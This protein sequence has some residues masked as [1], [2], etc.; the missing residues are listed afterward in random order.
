MELQTPNRMAVNHKKVI[1]RVDFNV[2]LEEYRGKWLVKD[3]RR[4]RDT[5]RTISYLLDHR[6]KVILISHLGRPNGKVIEKYSLEPIAEH[7]RHKFHWPVKFLPATVGEKVEEAIGSLE[8]GQCLLLENLRF[9]NEEKDNDVK[10]AQTLASYADVYINEAFSASHREHTSIVGIPKYL[11]SY[12]GFALENEVQTLSTLMDKPKRPFVVVLGGAKISDKVGAIKHLAKLADIVL[13]GGATAN[14]F[15]KA[16]GFEI[17][18]SFVEEKSKVKKDELDYTKVAS[19]IIAIHKTEK[20]LKDGYLPL[21]KLLYP[22][23]TVAAPK[24][25][26]S[27][28]KDVQ[29]IDLTHNMQDEEENVQLFYFDIGPNTRKLYEEIIAEAG[30]VFWNGPMGVWE[31]PLF[32]AGTKAIAKAIVSTKAKTVLGGGDTIAAAHHFNL[33]HKFKYISAAGG[34]ALE[35]LAGRNLP[36][37]KP[38]IKN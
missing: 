24:I 5:R 23:D 9:H 7:L 22:I 11:P 25:D 3:D 21:P 31:N 33:E 13:I 8:P 4:L 14:N 1:V 38:L 2:P 18:R 30:T 34:A 19:Q 36:G 20:V 37:L 12:A 28:K 29:V 6:A 15:L 10:F 16:E 35:F 32:A 17:Y 26:V 27:R